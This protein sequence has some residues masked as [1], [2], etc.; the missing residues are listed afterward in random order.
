IMD[1]KGHLLAVSEL[2]IVDVITADVQPQSGL[3]PYVRFQN[4]V[5]ILLAL[6][7]LLLASLLKRRLIVD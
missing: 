7:I 2:N 3:T 6:G 4:T 1:H 5:V